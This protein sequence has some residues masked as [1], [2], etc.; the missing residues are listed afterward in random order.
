MTYENSPQTSLVATHCA[1]C[2]RPLCDAVS[3]DLGIGP[4][5]R[6]RHGHEIIVDSATRAR[7]NRLVWEIAIDRNSLKALENCSELRALGFGKL[8][9]VIEAKIAM[10]IITCVGERYAVKAPYSVDATL[11]MRAV[12]GR[13][14][15]KVS[16]TNTFP[17]ASKV[18]LL[19]ALRQ[20]YPEALAIG[21]KGAFRL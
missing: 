21:P 8:A 18:A 17:I 12:P 3:V 13:I 14:W 15:D 9:G 1:V 2:A 10:I 11:L 5:C 6:K 20:A 4:E 19:G 16:K 7:A